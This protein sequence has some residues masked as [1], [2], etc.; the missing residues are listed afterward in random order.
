M[1]VE[2][3]YYILNPSLKGV[4]NVMQDTERWQAEDVINYTYRYVK[5]SMSVEMLSSK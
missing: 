5:T 3:A 4:H 2:S 1:N